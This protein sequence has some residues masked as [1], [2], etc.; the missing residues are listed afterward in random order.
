MVTFVYIS[1]TLCGVF[2]TPTILVSYENINVLWE[3]KLIHKSVKSNYILYNDSY[4]EKLQMLWTNIIF[5]FLLLS[6]QAL[7]SLAKLQE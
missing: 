2:L 3:C 5:H 7:Y 4:I 6:R 1:A